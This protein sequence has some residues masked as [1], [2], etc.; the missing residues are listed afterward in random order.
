MIVKQDPHEV[1]FSVRVEC[2]K[3]LGQYNSVKVSAYVV[4]IP[5]S[6]TLDDIE[7]LIELKISP[8]TDLIEK[9]M[10]AKLRA[11]QGGCL[12]SEG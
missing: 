2:T 9:A 12:E 7:E 8:V 5:S 3:N 6:A 10:K 11:M 4:D 1:V